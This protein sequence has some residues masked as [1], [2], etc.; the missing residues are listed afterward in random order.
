MYKC[1]GVEY[2]KV[3]IIDVG[4]SAKFG[5]RTHTLSIHH[6]V[7]T[8]I[9]MLISIILRIENTFRTLILPTLSTLRAK[10]GKTNAKRASICSS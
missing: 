10:Q 4:C 3:F 8:N 1:V 2:G 5:S 7:V 9:G 6:T